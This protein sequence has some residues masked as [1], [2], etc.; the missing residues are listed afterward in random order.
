M[1]GA[2]GFEP[3]ASRSRTARSS[4]LSYTPKIGRAGGTRTP[5]PL[6]VRQR[7]YHWRT[8]PDK[9]VGTAGFEP[10]TSCTPSRRAYQ[11]ALRSDCTP[12][13]AYPMPKAPNCARCG[14]LRMEDGA[15]VEPAHGASP[16]LTAYKAAVLPLH[17]PSAIY[18]FSKLEATARVELARRNLQSRMTGR[19]MSPW[20]SRW[21]LNPQC[22]PILS[23]RGLPSCLTRAWWESG[24]LN[25]EASV[26]KA[27]RY[28]CSRT[29]PKMV[30]HRGVEPRG[31]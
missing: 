14:G 31:Y 13:P 18:S 8:A 28:S 19:V 24:E 1:V 6:L 12:H 23:R 27:D 7:V 11:T 3:P 21:E 5:I 17:H 26:F 29:L 20:C 16:A 4:M 2:R 9:L 15:G 30:E 10:A 25:P 22:P